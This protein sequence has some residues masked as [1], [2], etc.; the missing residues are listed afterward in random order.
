[1]A[2]DVL[3]EDVMGGARSSARRWYDQEIWIGGLGRG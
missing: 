2:P 3:V 1:M